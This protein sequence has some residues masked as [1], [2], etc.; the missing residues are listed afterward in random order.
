LV[1]GTDVNRYCHLPE[2]QYIL[3][4]YK[5]DGTSV[6]LIDFDVISK[7]Y[8]KTA[9]Y[10]LKNKNRL[11][12]RERG[13]FEGYKWYRLGRSQ[14][15][16]I[17]EQTKLCVPR[18]VTNLYAAFN[19]EGNHF[20]DNVDVGGVTLKPKY[21]KQGLIYLLGLLNSKLLRWYFPFVSAPFRGGWMSANRQFLSQLPICTINF[22]DPTDKARR[23][24]MV[25]IVEQMLTLHAQLAAT[26]TPDDKTRLQR[27]IDATDHQIDQLVYDLYGLTE[28]E[29]QIVE[30]T[31][32][33]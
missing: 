27:Q 32:R 22:S 17:Q 10:L 23:D 5:V 11:E 33:R 2:R 8:P 16:G 13:K 30:G 15:L 25:N 31:S 21:Q 3:F 4:P 1:S 28:K 19:R 26:K 14:D 20:L 24:K 18:L 9:A 12:E 29:I 6:E 7:N